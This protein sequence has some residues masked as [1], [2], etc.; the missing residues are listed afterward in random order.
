MAPDSNDPPHDARKEGGDR[1]IPVLGIEESVRTLRTF[2][3]N[4]DCIPP[5]GI[6][7]GI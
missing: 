6:M 1:I 5:W 3:G 2:C 4:L 7:Y